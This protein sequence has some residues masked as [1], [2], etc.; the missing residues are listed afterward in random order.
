MTDL[1]TQEVHD[2]TYARHGPCCAGCDLWRWLNSAIGECL[3]SAPVAERERLAVIGMDC[4]SL[5]IGAGHV[6]T[7]AVHYCGDFKDDFDW[8]GLPPWYLRKIGWSDRN[9][10]KEQ[11]R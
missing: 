11:G 3:A 8:S 10:L 9:A 4:L 1:N 2:A 5:P 7:P 6:F